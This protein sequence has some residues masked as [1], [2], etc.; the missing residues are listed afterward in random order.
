MKASKKVQDRE[1]KQNGK[2]KGLI[3][4][5]VVIGLILI[6]PL[7]FAIRSQAGQMADA[8]T[9]I[10]GVTKI[11]GGTSTPLPVSTATIALPT[12]A[13]VVANGKEPP[14]CSFPLTQIKMAQSAPQNYTFSNPQVVLTAPQGNLYSIVE[15]LPDNQRVLITERLFNNTLN[16]ENDK[17]SIMLYS[18]ETNK[19][20]VYAVRRYLQDPPAWQ[21][22][23]NAVVYP[24]MNFLGFDQNTHALK[25]T[26]QVWVSYGEPNTVQMLADNLPQ[27]PISVKPDGSETLYFSDKE[28]SRRN[29]NMLAA[30][31]TPFDSTQWDYAKSRRNAPPVSYE[32]AW[33]PGTP[34]IF[35]YSDGGRGGG[36]YTFILNSDTGRVCELNFGGWAFRAH[37]SSDGR[38][39]AIARAQENFPINFSDLTVLDSMTGNLYTTGVV[40]QET[41][42]KHY[43]DDF[44]WAPDNHHL[45]V[46]G[47]VSPFQLPSQADIKN[48][49]RGLYLVDFISGQ[50]V[51]LLPA[52]SFYA[53]SFKSNLAW[54]PDGSKLLIRCSAV[55]DQIC[56]ISVQTTGQ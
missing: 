43:V 46:I 21:E 7:F 55:V 24:N 42:G 56:L 40:P 45:L 5:L 8:T 48:E 12:A 6:I 18:P 20:N 31:S 38:Y 34:L 15:W 26:R 30:S 4:T 35:L 39:L 41:K 17:Q 49:L 27:F 33:Q 13:P 16:G 51:R 28:I 10:P 29:T 23:A 37:W 32:M 25:F 1:I 11:P 47:K 19:S 53:D 52:N 50:S 22:G 9:P 2:V 36:G 44:V 54:S 14:A 3:E